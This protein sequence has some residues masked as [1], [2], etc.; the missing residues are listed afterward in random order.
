MQNKSLLMGIRTII[1]CMVLYVL[2]MTLSA[3]SDGGAGP[4]A[5]SVENGPGSTT[6]QPPTGGTVPP[7][8]PPATTTV[9]PVTTVGPFVVTGAT[10]VV[11]NTRYTYSATAANATAT[12]YR[13]SWGG[14]AGTVTTNPV[15][16]LWYKTGLYANT[17]SATISGSSVSTTL[18]VTAISEPVSGG[19]YHNCA[20]QT[21]GAVLCWGQNTSGQLGDG[22]KLD[23]PTPVAVLGLTNAVAVSAGGEYTCALKA[24]GSVVCWGDNKYGTLGN[25]TTATSAIT[26]P[27]S[28]LTDAIALSAG[29]SHV[30]ALRAT[31]TAVCWGTNGLGQLGTLTGSAPQSTPVAVNGLT[32][33]VALSIGKFGHGCA[34][35]AGGDVFCWGDDAGGQYVNG[36]VTD[37]VAISIGYFHSCALKTAGSVVC[38][39]D[40]SWGQLGNGTTVTNSVTPVAVSGLTN[41][42]ALKSGFDHTCAIKANGEVACWGQS[43]NNQLGQGGGLLQVQNTPVTAANLKNAAAL[44]AGSGHTCALTSA[45]G[46]QCWGFGP[47]GGTAQSAKTPT[48]V[49]GGDIFWK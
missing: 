20:L 34:L 14:S 38:W 29:D 21:S 11:T 12:N 16:K 4:D 36:S 26:V 41:A 28:G 39:G 46:V 1:Q 44:S 32:N 17:V 35:K 27:V 48:P 6:N 9:P 25:G 2:A 49:T 18:T 40:N 47:L 19:R 43:G 23:R 45:G 10:R 7:T 42:V 33:A 8:N 30:C 5:V 31:G 37:T 13:W 15:N 3:C 24:T 22:T